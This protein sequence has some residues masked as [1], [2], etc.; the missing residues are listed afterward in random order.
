MRPHLI[1]EGLEDDA[2][3]RGAPVVAAGEAGGARA[4]GAAL[5]R[6]GEGLQMAEQVGDVA[7]VALG[8]GGRC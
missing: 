5:G 8:A 7:R 4:D 2:A 3:L 6:G 1:P